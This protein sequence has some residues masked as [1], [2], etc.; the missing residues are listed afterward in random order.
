MAN[1]LAVVD[2]DKERRGH[3]IERIRSELS[4]IEGLVTQECS[5]GDFCAIWSAEARAPVSYVADDNGAAVLWGEAI[6]ETEADRINAAELKIFWNGRVD[7]SKAVFDGFYA[8][9]VYDAARGLTAGAD[10]LGVFP[11]YYWAG[12]DIFLVGS[13][14]ELFRYHPTFEVRLNPTGLVG[15]LLTMHIFG[16]ETL[17]MGVRRLAAGHL[18]SWQRQTAPVELLQYKIGASKKYF[19]LP[20][21]AQV[22][23]LDK[24]I[25]ETISRHVSAEANG[26]YGLML[27]GGLDS[28]VL[29]GYLGEKGIDA[30][31]LTMGL[32]TDIEMRCAVPVAKTLGFRHYSIDVGYERYPLCA[33]QQ[34]RWEHVANGFNLITNWGVHWYLRNFASHIV[35][36]H[37]IDAIVGTNYMTWAYSPASNTMSFETY[38]G[39][40]N[41]WGIKPSVLKKLLRGDLFKDLV[42][43]RIGCIK[44]VYEDYSDFESQRAWCFNLYNRQRFHVGGAA[45]A[46][47]FGAWPVMPALD[48]G[49]LESAGAMPASTIA[50]RRGEIELLCKRF[51]Q[52]A[53]LPLDRNSYNTEPLRPRLHYQLA[54]YLYGH[55]WPLH[56]WRN[57]EGNGKVERRYYFRTFDFNSPGWM[58][59]RRQA[60][61]Y[62]ERLFNLLDKDVLEELLPA[63]DVLVDFRD[64]I[65]DASGLKLLV[66]LMLWSKDHL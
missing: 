32:S 50:E 60:E 51:P 52:L 43:E 16:G 17:L 39:N 44:R 10:V 36:G 19:S 33:E 59:V 34:A 65:V 30:A 3:F 14:P 55:I 42:E 1:F 66:G 15:I 28:R 62:R 31:A 13:S 54:R 53:A 57:F 47:S 2:S 24:A 61:P 35:M 9:V 37:I 40:I 41:R 21:S 6:R 56:G 63:P 22:R 38:F 18:L 7:Y 64:K 27:S 25:D 5:T 20:F 11:V 26:D 12:K 46:L 4:P 23:I 8:G 49:L 58:A 48:R 45:W 29:A